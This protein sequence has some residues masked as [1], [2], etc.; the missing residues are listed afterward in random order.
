M[1]LPEL[2]GQAGR[3]LNDVMAHGGADVVALFG[4][5]ADRRLALAQGAPLIPAGYVVYA[6]IPLP[7]GTLIP[8][9]LPKL[10]FALYAG[11]TTKAPVLISST[12]ALPLTGHHVDQIVNPDEL[13]SSAPPKA[14]GSGLLYVVSATGSPSAPAS[15]RT[16][17]N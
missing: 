5:G 8:S 3:R 17:P 16:G 4:H 7:A 14:S 13:D 10:Q 11:R 12:R 9:Q 6:E 2:T 1:A 15:A